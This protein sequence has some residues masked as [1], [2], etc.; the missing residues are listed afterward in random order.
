MSCISITM[1][2]RTYVHMNFFMFWYRELAPEIC[3]LI[4]LHP[5][6]LIIYCS[7]YLLRCYW[8]FYCC[9]PKATTILLVITRGSILELV[10]NV[11]NAHDSNDENAYMFLI[12]YSWTLLNSTRKWKQIRFP[13]HLFTFGNVGKIFVFST[14]IV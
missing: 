12:R 13:L 7:S 8:T 10:H 14:N 5:L 11:M 9:S 4:L 6:Y 2:L 1:S 3:Y